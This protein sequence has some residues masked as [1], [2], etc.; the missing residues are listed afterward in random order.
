MSSLVTF[1]GGPE[2]LR[3]SNATKHGLKARLRMHLVELRVNLQ[4]DQILIVLFVTELQ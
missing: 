1:S 2:L 3:Q 4:V